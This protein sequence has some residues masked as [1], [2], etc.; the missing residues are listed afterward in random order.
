[1]AREAGPQQ[2]VTRLEVAQNGVAPL[3]QIK[4]VLPGNEAQYITAGLDKLEQHAEQFARIQQE[5][6]RKV[7]EAKEKTGLLVTMGDQKSAY[8]Q[9]TMDIINHPELPNE[10]KAKMLQKLEDDFRATIQ[11]A[12]PQ[13]QPVVASEVMGTIGAVK[14]QAQ[15]VF[16]K[17]QQ[18]GIK[19]DLE[20][21]VGQLTLDAAS[22]G[23]L[24]GAL[25]NFDAL[26]GAYK[27]AGLTDAHFVQTRQKFEQELLQTDIMG[28]LK[29][30]DVKS[31]A[32][33]LETINNLLTRLTEADDQ[34]VPKNWTRLDPHT[35]NADIAAVINKKNQIEADMVAGANKELTQLKSNFSVGMAYYS[36]ALKNGDI[37]P[38]NLSVQLRQQAQA[39]MQLDPDKSAGVMGLLQLQKVEQE[40][41][42]GHRATESAKDP[43]WGTGVR[44]IS[45]ADVSTPEAL[46]AKFAENIKMGQSVK[47]AKGLTFVPVLRNADMEGIAKTI[48]ANPANGIRMVET[49]GQSLGQDGKNSLMVIAGQM[50]NS[51]DTAAPAVAAIIYNV[52]KGDSNTAQVIASGMEVMRNKSITMP[53]EADLRDGFNR[54][55]GDAMAERSA[56]RGV[57]YEAYKTAYASMAAR[58][59]VVDGNF[60][61]DA[62]TE[63][64]KRVVGTVTKWNG[65]SVL[66]PDGWNEEKFRD[67]VNSISPETVQA[68]GGIHGMTTERA[69]DFI[70]DDARLQAVSPGR[71]SL[72]YEG[73]QW[74][75]T[76]GRLFIIDVNQPLVKPAA[77]PIDQIVNNISTGM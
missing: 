39:M 50:A 2:Q 36:D 54:M 72:I 15:E 56:N 42:P 38:P 21:R 65:S 57:Q 23:D 34:N 3:S 76:G 63:A 60:D 28:N 58:K 46:Q 12:K 1:V 40:F 51:K 35:R 53:K 25:Q 48:E 9:N 22:S 17:N 59:N 52:A 69:A 41:G 26:H 62:A 20:K 77:R 49:L 31:G 68:W 6:I 61:R 19:A 16:L 71:Y 4:P 24:D 47:Q 13:F 75:T 45:F 74:L 33:A 18:D 73:K 29:S 66:I 14:T 32:P 30:V 10:E 5:E 7:N 44:P 37:I 43:L 11:E 55:I 27:S 64:F 70:K 67:Y 8:K